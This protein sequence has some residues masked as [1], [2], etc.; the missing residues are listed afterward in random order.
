TPSSGLRSL[1][2]LYS[3][4]FLAGFTVK[5]APE[6]E[7]WMLEQREH[8][9]AL[10]VKLAEFVVERA[11]EADATDTA[12]DALNRLLALDVWNERAHRQKMLLLARRGEKLQALA[13]YQT[14]R[15]TLADEFGVEPTPETTALYERIRDAKPF[16]GALPVFPTPFFPRLLLDALP[17]KLRSRSF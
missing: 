11:L 7:V 3:G 10:E 8:C 17:N 13:Q 12:L 2:A 6:F 1:L 4:E 15:K 9:R 16:A 14:A 5:H